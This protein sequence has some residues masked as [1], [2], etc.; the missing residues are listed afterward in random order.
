MKTRH[1]NKKRPNAVKAIAVA[2]LFM[3]M[4]ASV[5]AF[6]VNPNAAST[7]WSGDT[8]GSY[9]IGGPFNPSLITFVSS[10]TSVQVCFAAQSAPPS[11]FQKATVV[12]DAGVAGSPFSGNYTAAGVQS[13][14][15]QIRGDGS[16]PTCSAVLIGNTSG[17]RWF[18]GTGV[19]PVAGQWTTNIVS[20]NQTTF[21]QQTGWVL[22]VQMY[23][24]WLPVQGKS[25]SE[26]SALW[27]ADL[28]DVGAVGVSLEQSGTAAQSYTIDQFRLSNAGGFM[29]PPAQLSPFQVKAINPASPGTTITWAC[30]AGS[31]YTVYR[32]ENLLGQFHLLDDAKSQNMSAV[33]TGYMSYTDTTATNTGPYFYRVTG[34]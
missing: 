30:V 7:A 32:S 15:F 5:T 13:V 11:Y 12:A 23:G 21:D 14:S 20:F 31:T 4:W 9:A 8:T 26:L 33:E 29:T 2:G 27:Q 3:G 25:S 34:Q 10:G 24:Y 22:Y 17:N 1:D 6:G 28:M 19:S 18:Y 16:V